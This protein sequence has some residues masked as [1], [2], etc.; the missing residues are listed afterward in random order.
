MRRFEIP[1]LLQVAARDALEAHRVAADFQDAV[2]RD[3]SLPRERDDPGP[4]RLTIGVVPRLDQ[5][6]RQEVRIR[7]LT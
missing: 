3:N 2:S 4:E 6:D 7:E 5:T 1:M